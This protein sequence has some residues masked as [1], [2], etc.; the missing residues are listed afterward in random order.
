MLVSCFNLS[1]MKKL[2]VFVLILC[3]YYGF[4]Q[5]GE[6]DDKMLKELAENAC[7]CVDSV[8]VYDRSKDEIATSVSKCIDDQTSGYQLIS[9]LMGAND[10]IKESKGKKKKQTVEISINMD[11]GSQ[12]YKTYYYEMERYLMDNC[13]SMKEKISTDNKQSEKSFSSDPEALD[14][15]SKGLRE[16]EKENY[17]Q[18]ITY[19]EE[20]LKIDPQF[21][22]AWDN[23]GVSYRKA[24]DLDKAMVAYQK[25]LEI[26]P[27][28]F[29][30]L[31]NI[32]I[33]YQYK[34]EFQKAVD[35]YERLA[36]IDKNNPE[37]YY[38]IGQIYL[39]NIPDHEK[40]LSNMCKAY[41][42]Y[43][44][45]KSPY[46]ADAEKIIN[47]LYTEMKKEG[48]EARFAEILKEN[49]IKTQ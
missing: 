21:A 36:E 6:K 10:Q 27:K 29:M 8:N 23:L 2:I 48:K 1:R 37:V 22:F 42:L 45:Q 12:E 41:N 13:K 5:K 34:K 18:A 17:K 28:G 26:D 38:G 32:A 24:G 40:S 14:L 4:S 33:V 16:V 19:F 30:P 43:A 39:S 7:K 3:G 25:S 11:R 20:A 9:Q 35:A 49:N 46:R 47:I 15:Y 44:D 31:Q